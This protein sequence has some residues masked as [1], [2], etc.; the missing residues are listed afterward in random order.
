MRTS[1]FI[2]LNKDVLLEWI[3]DDDNLLIENYKVVINTL[4]DQYNFVNATD[5]NSIQSVTNN[6]QSTNLIQIN[7][8]NN[9]WGY[10]DETVYPFL[11]VSTYL[12]NIPQRYDIVRLYFPV[13][14]SFDEY[15]GFLLNLYVLDIT[16][17]RKIYL[18]NFFFD[19]TDTNRSLDLAAPPFLHDDVLWGKYVEIQI[20]SASVLSKQVSQTTTGGI[21]LVPTPGSINSNLA[22][23][24]LAGVNPNSPIFIDFS[25]LLKKDYLFNQITFLAGEPYSTSIAQTPE[26]EDLSVDIFPSEKGDFFEIVGTYNNT[27]SDFELF[28]EQ[29]RILGNYF[30]V[31]YKVNTIE[32]N[33]ITNTVQYFTESNFD[34]AI[35][36]RPI[37]TFSTTTA[38]IDV[39]MSLVNASDS[40]TIERRATYTMLQ[41]EVAKYSRI[42]TKI[43]VENA[44]NVSVY[45]AR[46]DKLEIKS[47]GEPKTIVEKVDVPYPVL[48]D[49]FKVI[50]KNTSEDIQDE[51]YYG[52]GQLQ[53]LLY[54]FDN[55]IKLNIAKQSKDGNVVPYQLPNTGRITMSF[56]SATDE[57]SIDLY[58]DSGLVDL[59][60][61][62]VIFKIEQQYMN[63]ITNFYKNGY[64]QFYIVMRTKENINTILYAGR[65]VIYNEYNK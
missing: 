19:Q 39:I 30:Y 48:Y 27:S 42:L 25:F 23:P 59:E 18:S 13:N 64:D 15:I 36:F 6:T 32:Q 44:Y 54:P 28:I 38:A 34:H 10:M 14:Y 22:G 49:N 37:I 29:Q 45:N 24:T 11:Q 31:T 26:F 43:N 9:K 5:T 40:N 51:V 41:D 58:T 8:E 56:K 3:Y 47:F 20:P 21:T 52:V 33:V 60:K 50:T 2:N 17:K 16:D 46:S 12:Y 7:E 57:I 61:G 53:I 63:T 65:Y 55:V 1:K 4:D 35:W 62:D